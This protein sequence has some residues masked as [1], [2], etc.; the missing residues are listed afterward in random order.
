MMGAVGAGFLAGR[1]VKAIDTGAVAEAAKAGVQPDQ[2]EP[3]DRAPAAPLTADEG[4]SGQ[5][6]HGSAGDLQAAV[7]P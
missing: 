7:R 5:I 4:L 6:G 1:L 2:T 3:L